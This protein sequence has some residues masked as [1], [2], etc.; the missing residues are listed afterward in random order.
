MMHQGLQ[1]C[2]EAVH[3]IC[4]NTDTPCDNKLSKKYNLVVPTSGSCGSGK[5]VKQKENV[6][7]ECEFI[8]LCVDI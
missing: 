4:K 5:A 1:I 2:L 7:S 3:F 8:A 6:I